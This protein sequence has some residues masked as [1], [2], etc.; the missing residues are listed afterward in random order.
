[1]ML[2]VGNYYYV[3]SMLRYIH[4]EGNVFIKY[5]VIFTLERMDVAYD[6]SI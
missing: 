3:P 1:M 2:I 5:A 4:H 6:A